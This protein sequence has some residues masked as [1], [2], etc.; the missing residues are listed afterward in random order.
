M[1]DPPLCPP[2]FDWWSSARLN[3]LVRALRGCDGVPPPRSDSEFWEKVVKDCQAADPKGSLD[4]EELAD[5]VHSEF[6]SARAFSCYRTLAIQPLFDMPANDPAFGIAGLIPS[7]T[8]GLLVGDLSCAESRLVGLVRGLQGVVYVASHP[9]EALWAADGISYYTIVV[10]IQE[11]SKTL[12]SQLR[13]AVKFLATHRPALICSSSS[14][15]PACVLAAFNYCL[16]RG[17]TPMSDLVQTAEREVGL[18][19]GEICGPDVAELEA[20]ATAASDH[21]A[22]LPGMS[23][24]TSPSTR[25]KGLSPLSRSSMRAPGP[26][27]SVRPV[28]AADREAFDSPGTSTGE[29]VSEGL[30]TPKHRPAVPP[31]RVDAITSCDST[32]ATFEAEAAAADTPLAKAAKSDAVVHPNDTETLITRGGRW[33]RNADTASLEPD[34][35]DEMHRKRHLLPELSEAVLGGA[36]YSNI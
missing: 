6:E 24:T 33:K 29:A 5:D 10:S 35:L 9:M 3:V 34:S 20:F 22:L 18:G 17:A 31:L 32:M 12:S 13:G 25:P 2:R 16:C 23:P 14:A 30:T 28:V 27:V 11:P 19:P 7:G 26:A 15:L 8:V 4:A 36:G 1:L 21:E